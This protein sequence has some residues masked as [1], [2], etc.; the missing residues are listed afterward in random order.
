MTE[1]IILYPLTLR[2]GDDSDSYKSSIQGICDKHTDQQWKRLILE[3]KKCIKGYESQYGI[4]VFNV[5][6]YKNKFVKCKM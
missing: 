5:E 6:R 1:Q 3:F 4:C 2:I